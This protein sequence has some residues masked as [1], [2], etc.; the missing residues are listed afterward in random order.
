ML[1]MFE[2]ASGLSGTIE[3]NTDLF[4]PRTIERLMGH[5]QTLLEAA[6]SNP[7]SE[8]ARLRL[9]TTEETEQLARWSDPRRYATELAQP[10]IPGLAVAE[11][12]HGIFEAQAASTPHATAVVGGQQRLSYDQL[13]CQANQLARLLRLRGVDRET[14]VGIC[15]DRSADLLVAVLAVLKAGAA[16]VPLDTIYPSQRIAEILADS[17]PILCLTTGALVS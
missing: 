7:D 9:I 3:Y 14:L 5:F 17:R 10:S 4:D 12:I 8:I 2:G 13:N 11:S 16:Y 15:L 1:T 6:I